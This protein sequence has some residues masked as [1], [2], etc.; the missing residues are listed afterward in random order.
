[1]QVCPK[2]K[3]VER[4]K[5]RVYVAKKR[6]LASAENIKNNYLNN[7][8]P[9]EAT[10]NYLSSNELKWTEKMNARFDSDPSNKCSQGNS[11]NK[12]ISNNTQSISNNCFET[13]KNIELN[14]VSHYSNAKPNLK[15]DQDGTMEDEE[16][17][18]E[19]ED[20]LERNH[21]KYTTCKLCEGR[22]N[23]VAIKK[24]EPILLCETKGCNREYHLKCLPRGL[25]NSS[26]EGDDSDL[27][28]YKENEEEPA[29]LMGYYH[30]PSGEIYCRACSEEGSTTVLRQYFERCDNLRSNFS[31]SR[32]YVR[33]LLER[34]MRENIAGNAL[35]EGGNLVTE[36]EVVQLKPPPRSELWYAEE[37]SWMA[38]GIPKRLHSADT[39]AWSSAEFLIGKPV[40]L[41][42]NLDNEY[43]SGRILDWR[44]CSVY[45]H[46][47]EGMQQKL[48]D[49]SKHRSHISDLGYY[50]TGAI[51][52]CEFLVCFPAGD[53][54]REKELMQWM[55]LEEHS[56]AVGIA[57]VRGQ[58][59]WEKYDKW[60]PAMVLARSALELVPVRQFL[61]EGPRG[62]LFA[63]MT[64]DGKDHPMKYAKDFW[65]LTSFFGGDDY[66]L[67]N[68]RREMRGL[69]TKELLK[70]SGLSIDL[71]DGSKL[72]QSPSKDEASTTEAAPIETSRT[73]EESTK[74]TE[75]TQKPL[76]PIKNKEK[77]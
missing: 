9:T 5:S 74:P 26:Y 18:E 44:T 41:Y 13:L 69:I 52:T 65:A 42:C 46:S 48:E 40:R 54:G 28:V 38:L 37:M 24:N 31:S 1:M 58:Y 39:D 47:N 60:K 30:I 21:Y 68:L 59:G 71:S 61:Y 55:L 64:R 53:Q 29:E 62:E 34:H 27:F 33:N 25:V 51:S 49:N 43:H 23:A 63:K 3:K 66:A 10:N 20:V 22:R 17:E 14:T 76:S 35:R 7:D 45:P 50:G 19:V 57:L 4:E 11:S 15:S 8:S 67:L 73:T 32:G 72:E 2:K 56:L 70:K 77:S 6:K 16:P 12:Q 75:E 36:E